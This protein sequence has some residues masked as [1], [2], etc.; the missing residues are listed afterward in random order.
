MLLCGGHESAAQTQHHG[1]GSQGA[2]SPHGGGPVHSPAAG[3]YGGAVRHAPAPVI[4][5]SV[6]H[7]SSAP[8]VHAASRPPSPSPHPAVTPQP[9]PATRGGV[10]IGPQAAP[11]HPGGVSHGSVAIGPFGGVNRGSFSN[12]TFGT[13]FTHATALH[14]SGTHIRSNFHH[15]NAFRPAW[16]ALYP[17]AWFLPGWAAA[18]FWGVPGWDTVAAFGGYPTAPFYYDY[19]STV[20]TEG[21]VVYVNGESAGT[22]EQYAQQAAGFAD[23][24]RSV[25]P[26]DAPDQWTPLGVFAMV[27][28]GETKSSNIFE[29][30]VN[31]DGIL[32]GNYYN[33]LTDTN[34][35]IY[36]SVDKK[37][38]RAAWTVGNRKT[39]VYEAG[40]ANLTKDETTMMVHYGQEKSQQYTLVRMKQ[41]EGAK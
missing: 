34:E 19:G 32:R 15:F 7:F 6:T 36:G 39:P 23:A 8:P 35:P 2:M 24:G 13:H 40:I 22:I 16:F 4:G 29:L 18:Q 30:A 33:S 17:G 26:G 28:D 37:S 3:S 9:V 31:K 1:G 11:A 14:E 41:P 38:R 27:S 21:P 10:A 20:V 25:Q 12:T 5:P